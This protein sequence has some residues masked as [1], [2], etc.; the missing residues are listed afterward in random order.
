LPLATG[1]GFSGGGDFL[2]NF[3]GKLIGILVWG[4]MKKRP[5]NRLIRG[6]DGIL[7][8]S[9]GFGRLLHGGVVT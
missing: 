9:L 5:Q 8:A 3:P 6:K 4:A 1:A 2:I 7:K